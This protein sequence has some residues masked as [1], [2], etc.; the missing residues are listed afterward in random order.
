M[1][2]SF[3]CTICPSGE[4]GEK[5]DDDSSKK[6]RMKMKMAKRFEQQ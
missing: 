1:V 6:I 5:I 3:Y 4:G 2:S